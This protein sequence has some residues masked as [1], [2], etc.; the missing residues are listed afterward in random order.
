[1][2]FRIAISLSCLLL[3]A[4][5]GG[6]APAPTSKVL[7]RF[8]QANDCAQL[9]SYVET[10]VKRARDFSDR[11][12]PVSGPIFAEAPNAGGAEDDGAG[13]PSP[14]TSG[15]GV[16]QSD[17]A[18]ADTERGLLHVF[19]GK[20]L[21]ILKATPVAQAALIGEFAFDFTPQEL[22]SVKVGAKYYG[23]VFGGGYGG[24]Q[25][26]P[27]SDTMI[28]PAPGQDQS[29]LVVLDLSDPTHPQKLLQE[30]AP[31]HFLEARALLDSGKI[32]WVSERWIPLGE[33]PG[34]S[35]LFAEKTSL[36][37]GAAN[38]LPL[39]SCENSLLYQN[40]S[41]DPDY[42]PYSLTATTISLLDLN[43]AALPVDSQTIWSPAYRTLVAANAERLLLAQNVDGAERSDTELYRFDLGG[44]T[45]LA[46][47]DGA[48][49]PGN[50]LNQFFIDEK[51]G[52]TRVFHNVSQA[53]SCPNCGVAGGGG[54]VPVSEPGSPGLLKAQASGSELATGNY[55]S[56]YRNGNLVGR[57]GPFET[58]EVPFAARFVGRLGCVITFLQIDP[59]T[60]F[61]LDNPSQPTKLGEL[62]IEGVSF[63]LEDLGRG[64]L[65]GLGRDGA[66]R[67]VANLFDISDPNRP[68]LATQLALSD[69][70]GFGWSQAFYDYRAL[71]KDAGLEHFALPID[72][73]GGSKL[74]FFSVDLDAKEIQA[75]GALMKNYTDA[76]YDF[77]SRAYF[78][79]DSVG[80]LSYSAAEIFSR[81]GLNSA[82]ALPLEH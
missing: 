37:E 40:E 16:V 30:T 76:N 28:A 60:C 31:G 22:V 57:S 6:S 43:L 80:T 39:S 68:Q 36:R 59:L 79:S 77:F 55:V 5:S 19:S 15:G 46:F 54:D 47:L 18:F 42:A 20:N 41:L 81:S 67:V 14:T 58:E 82:F 74:A 3:G 61:D 70:S 35:V 9:K 49:V 29:I 25:P 17:V 65:L 27:V 66:G 63:H 32:A 78:F 26:I 50:I 73:D 8:Q 75:E 33:N 23:V 13:A 56:A 12:V 64:F 71:A 44:A 11:Q 34:D 51:D 48:Q 72:V 7:G 2:K 52:V 4:C 24:A 62:E 21:K 38:A 45:P 53:F 69:P 1:M 10:Y